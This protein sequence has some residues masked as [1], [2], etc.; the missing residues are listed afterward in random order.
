ML[1]YPNI[2]TYTDCVVA[3]ILLLVLSPLMMVILLSIIV[4]DRHNPIFVQARSGKNG[5]PFNLIKFRTFKTE[6][7]KTSK[8]SQKI[9]T[10]SYVTK[11]GHFLRAL[12]LD[13]LPQLINV[14]KSDMSLVGPRPLLIEY[15]PYYSEEE[16]QRFNTKPGITGLAQV[17]GRNAISWESKF[18]FDIEYVNQMNLILDIQIMIR[19]FFSLFSH[20][21]IYKNV[22]STSERLDMQRKLAHKIPN[23][24]K[25]VQ[26]N[27]Q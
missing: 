17:N 23:K 20:K 21:I 16:K 6:N 7:L 11:L 22:V 9:A 3:C 13:E 12:S 19:T 5:L 10:D 1:I 15:M 8:Q 4:V 2:K 24:L 18:S 14:I 27:P 25:K 26:K